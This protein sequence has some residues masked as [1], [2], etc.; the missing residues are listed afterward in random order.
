MN[1][2]YLAVIAVT[3]LGLANIAKDYRV[4]MRVADRLRIVAPPKETVQD[5]TA[6][7]T[8]GPAS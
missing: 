8:P 1:P 5:E 3:V 7:K 2:S 6:E 4:Q